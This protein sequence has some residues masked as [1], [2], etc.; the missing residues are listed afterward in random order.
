MRDDLLEYYERELTFLRRMGAEF[1]E[2]YPKVASRLL[3]EADKCDDPHVE[4][5][6]EGFAFLAARVH[7]KV[8]DEFPEITAALFNVLFPYYV[9]PIPAMSMVEFHV[10][11]EQGKMMSGLKIP[12]GTMLYSRPVAGEPC[13]F[14]TCYDTS[15]WP[16]TVA[17]AEW[18]TP[19]RL[20]PPVKAAD[21]VGALRLELRCLPDVF[22]DKLELDSVRFHLSGDSNVVHTVYEL[23]CNNC[24]EILVRDAKPESRL[25][26]LRLPGS[27]IEPAGFAENE[28]VLPFPPRSFAGYRLLQEYFAFPEK[29]FFLDLKGFDQIRAAGFREAIEVIFLISPFE[30]SERRQVLE[31]GVSQ[32]TFRL[33]CTPIV[34]LFPQTS[35][36]ILLHERKY[37]YRV[38]P[39]IHRQETMDVFSIDEVIGVDPHSADQVRFEPFYSYR[40]SSDRAR[41]QAFW[42]A[43]RRTTGWRVGG[44]ADIYISLVDLA[45]QPV[46]PDL[47]AI[48]LRLTCSN[49]DLPSRLPFGNPNGDFELEGGGPVKRIVCLTRPTA[50]LEPPLGKALLWRLISQLSLNYLSLVEGGR[51]ALQE[52]LRL[53]NFSE[54]AFAEKQIQGI[55]GVRSQP[56]FA[57]IV[58]ENGVS[59]ARGRRVEVEFDEEQFA[60]GGVY[61]FASLLERFLAM[62]VSINSFCLLVSRSKQRKEVLREWSP[63]AGHRVL[64]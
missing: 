47:K 29:F 22:F 10:D 6:L 3:L 60:G 9:R 27:L 42:H 26:P 11:P 44:G 45:A 49:R 8:D 51:E 62:Y 53:H 59:F 25:K 16:V 17:A 54:A 1:A 14:Q 56:W 50:V 55:S 5:L 63:R 13:K 28:S 39:S 30:R 34:N 35:E 38:V 32:K 7:L 33:G 61:L 57:R 19:D 4:R 48:T 36:P 41:N 40:H 31:N 58:S 23:L 64:L 15:L 24:A 43:T 12:R 2:K 18:K 52:I 20:T 37:E 46:H 21:S